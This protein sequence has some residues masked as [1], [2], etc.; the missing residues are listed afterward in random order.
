[1]FTCLQYALYSIHCIIYTVYYIP[2]NN[3]SIYNTYT[4]ELISIL[5]YYLFL[6]RLYKLIVVIQCFK[7]NNFNDNIAVIIISF[8]Y[9][10]QTGVDYWSIDPRRL[11]VA[12]GQDT[13]KMEVSLTPRP[14]PSPRQRMWRAAV[15]RQLRRPPH[16]PRSPRQPETSN[17]SP[18]TPAAHPTTTTRPALRTPGPTTRGAWLALQ[19]PPCP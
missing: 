19:P 13:L 1:M 7:F 17:P 5:I 11:E 18:H 8:V 9:L 14:D 4:G 15:T 3:M 16:T 6:T 10:L 2:G 12:S